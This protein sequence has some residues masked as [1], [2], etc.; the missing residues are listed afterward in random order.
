MAKKK[1]DVAIKQTP[2]YQRWLQSQPHLFQKGHAAP[3]RAPGV[4]NKFTRIMKDAILEAIELEGYDRKGKDGMTGFF[5]MVARKDLRAFCMLANRAMP[6]QI[7]AKNDTKV[8]VTYQSI[9]EVKKELAARGI[10]IE[11]VQQLLTHRSDDAM[12]I[13]GE[14]ID[15]NDDDVRH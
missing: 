4:Q 15:A 6:L 5:R 14:L 2:E 3:G 7:E 8:E 1:S 9:D 13:D 10:S 12:I 11:A